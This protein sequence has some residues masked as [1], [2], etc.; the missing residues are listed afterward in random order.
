MLQLRRCQVGPRP[1]R[2]RGPRFCAQPPT[3]SKLTQRKQRSSSRQT[4]ALLLT[5]EQPVGIVC[6]ITPWNFPFAIPTWK[7]APALGFGNAVVWKPAEAASGSAVL[8]TEAFAQAGLPNGVLNLVTGSGPDLSPALTGDARLAAITFTGSGRVGTS[9][10]HAV[11]DRNVKV[12][13]ELG[14]KNPAIVLADAD[15]PDAALQIARGAML[16]TGQRCTATSRVYVEA[17]VAEE[18]VE[19]LRTQIDRFV[20]G[21]PFDDATDIGPVAFAERLDAVAG[22]IELARAEHAEVIAAETPT[23]SGCFIAPTLLMGVDPTSRLVSEEIF[24]PVL[25]VVVVPDFDAAVAA[26]NDTEFGL[27]SGV[28][29]GDISKAMRFIRLTQS[30]VPQIFFSPSVSAQASSP[31]PLASPDVELHALGCRTSLYRK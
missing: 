26:A 18:F 30:G 14:G 4:W 5:I 12:Q 11:A 7:L 8:L 2:Q 16:A 28:F 15:L 21:D 31:A 17:P 19:L 9:L 27:S 10:R 23:S 25:I 6:A 1:L 3:I 22:Y 29:T 24:G 13:L 20:V